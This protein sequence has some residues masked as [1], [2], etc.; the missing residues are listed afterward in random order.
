ME[1]EEEGEECIEDLYSDLPPL[2][3]DDGTPSYFETY[4]YVCAACWE[5]GVTEGCRH[6]VG[7]AYRSIK[8][9]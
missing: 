9:E 7:T 6:K 8:D 4:T 3:P 2:I 1:K 5:R